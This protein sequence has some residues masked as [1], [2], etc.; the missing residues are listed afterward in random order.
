ME[1]TQQPRRLPRRIGRGI[2]AAFESCERLTDI[3]LSA[4][5]STCI[6]MKPEIS[7]EG[8]DL[9]YCWRGLL[10]RG[11]RGCGNTWSI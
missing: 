8:S 11:C 9:V 4:N 6:R 2:D 7:R 10:E 3:Y 1:N 5:G